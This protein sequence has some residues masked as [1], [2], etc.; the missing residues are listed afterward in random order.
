MTHEVSRIGKSQQYGA[1]RKAKMTSGVLLAAVSILGAS[2]GV[3]T[4]RSEVTVA[5]GTSTHDFS[6]KLAETKTTVHTNELKT[7]PP[8]SQ[9][10]VSKG[11]IMEKRPI[12]FFPPPRSGP[13]VKPKR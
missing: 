4:A 2:L 5:G 9:K 10:P 8:V 11:F 6:T 1:A 7:N 3:T 13:Q 12:D